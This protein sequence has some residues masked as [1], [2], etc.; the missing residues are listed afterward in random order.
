MVN[1]FETFPNLLAPVKIGGVMFRNRM[2]CAPTGHTDI[3]YDGQPSLD[4]VM[5][6]ERKA[7]GGAATVTCGEVAVDPDEFSDGRWPREITRTSNYNYPRLASAVSRH[8]AVPVVELQFT[9]TESRSR[10]KPRPDPAW[11]WP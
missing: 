1:P 2:F 6:F 9:G 10:G 4:A 8:G 11:P 3:V 5:Y 7:V